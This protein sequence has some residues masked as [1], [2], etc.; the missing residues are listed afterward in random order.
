MSRAILMGRRGS[1]PVTVL[2][3]LTI[4]LFAFTLI[5]FS[6]SKGQILREIGKTAGLVEDLEAKAK[7]GEYSGSEFKEPIVETSKSFWFFG[8]PKV[9]ISVRK[10]YK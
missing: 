3:I 7:A 6:V 9:E 8:E 4:A 10:I 1:I 2:V 5:A